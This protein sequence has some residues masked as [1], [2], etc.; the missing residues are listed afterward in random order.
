MNFKALL[1]ASAFVV[2]SFVLPF[3]MA[4]SASGKMN[5]DPAEIAKMD[6][7]MQKKMERI[8]SR[9]VEQ[10]AKDKASDEKGRLGMTSM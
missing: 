4:H 5:C 2:G 9:K 7:K 3:S 8:C 6:A 10:D 1:T